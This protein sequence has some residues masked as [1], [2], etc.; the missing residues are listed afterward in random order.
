MLFI[1]GECVAAIE[2]VERP[3]NSC[4]GSMQL[5]I[6]R[7]IAYNIRD[8]KTFASYT[9]LTYNDACV[10]LYNIMINQ[11]VQGSK[12][13]AWCEMFGTIEYRIPS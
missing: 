11:V 4:I 12:I 6:R 7:V 1:N 2:C 13:A 8:M 10:K 3:T 5:P 9:S